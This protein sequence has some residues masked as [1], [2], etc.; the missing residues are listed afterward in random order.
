R[1]ARE[2]ISGEVSGT[3]GRIACGTVAAWARRARDFA[4]APISS[5][6]P[7]PTYPFP[8][9]ITHCDVPELRFE[10]HRPRSHLSVPPADRARAHAQHVAHGLFHNHQG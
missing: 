7:L 4:H 10:R 1:A 6:A 2:D 8:L 3:V 9:G 5:V